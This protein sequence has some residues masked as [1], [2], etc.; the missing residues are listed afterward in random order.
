MIC[1]NIVLIISCRFGSII[2]NPSG[3]PGYGSIN[4]YDKLDKNLACVNADSYAYYA[5]V[6][7]SVLIAFSYLRLIYIT[8]MTMDNSLPDR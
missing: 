6:S 8:G 2:D 3:K 1:G 5:S 7:I 4:V